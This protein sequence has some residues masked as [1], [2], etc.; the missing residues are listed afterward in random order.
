MRILEKEAQSRDGEIRLGIFVC[1]KI[2]LK[3]GSGFACFLSRYM[4]RNF[5]D[6]ENFWFSKFLCQWKVCGEE[7]FNHL[8]P[9][10]VSLPMEI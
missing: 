4:R 2:F 8:S 7:I 1:P 10:K 9:A 3:T 5:S 6:F